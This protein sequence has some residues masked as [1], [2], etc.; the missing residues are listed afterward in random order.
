MKTLGNDRFPFTGMTY[1]L[2]WLGTIALFALGVDK[3]RGG[4]QTV[5]GTILRLAVGGFLVVL[6]VSLFF[7]LQELAG[8]REEVESLRRAMLSAKARLGKT[9]DEVQDI[10]EEAC[11]PEATRKE[12][13]EA[14]G[15]ALDVIEGEK[16][17]EQ[18]QGNSA[19]LRPGMPL[20]HAA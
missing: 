3:L 15:K 13:A 8:L 19:R 2:S 7:S 12:L 18:E 11:A 4:Y 17:S 1:V 20:T 6:A 16:E 5:V 10:L 14:V 9:L